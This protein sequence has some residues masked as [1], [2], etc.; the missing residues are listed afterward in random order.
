MATESHP[1]REDRQELFEAFYRALS[2]LRRG[3]HTDKLAELLLRRDLEAEIVALINGGERVVMYDSVE[4]QVIAEAFDAHGFGE[5]EVL[6]E[7]ASNPAAWLDAHRD[8]VDWVRSEYEWVLEME[9][10]QSAW[11]Y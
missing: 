5:T 3:V 2:R 9:D 8:N 10:E 4:H 11:S 7:R 6:W 1:S